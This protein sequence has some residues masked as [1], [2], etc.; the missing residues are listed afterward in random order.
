[1]FKK[2]DL[3]KHVGKARK[4]VSLIALYLFFL[5][6]PV[7]VAL[8]AFAGKPGPAPTIPYTITPLSDIG[9]IGFYGD[10]I[11]LDSGQ[12][13]ERQWPTFSWTHPCFTEFP[14][15]EV[16]FYDG[17]T[18]R[19]LTSND[20]TDDRSPVLHNGRVA[21]YGNIISNINTCEMVSEIFFYDGASVKQISNNNQLGI[22][23]P[24]THS[25]Q[26]IW[27]QKVGT[28]YELFSYDGTSTQ[29]ITS[30]GNYRNAVLF[31][32]KIALTLFDGNDTEVYIW[33]N[34]AMTQ[35]TNNNYDDYAGRFD[36]RYLWVSSNTGTYW[37]DGVSMREV[38]LPAINWNDAS[39]SNGQVVWS[40]IA[41]TSKRDTDTEI[42]FWDGSTTRQL[43]NNSY[44]D[45]NP[46]IHNG[47]VAWNGWDG[48]DWEVYVWNGTAAYQLTNNTTDDGV[49][50]INNGQVV[51]NGYL[52]TPK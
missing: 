36:G 43:T 37:W 14:D 19:Q 47:Q 11:Q 10:G 2:K 18:T 1:M 3:M 39:V 9:L 41:S 24:Q 22:D 29:Q 32:G 12:L 5:A 46:R 27:R 51:W 21:W 30:G 42:F 38:T 31:N 35:F 52:A 45:K 34:G 7:F 50:A 44:D 48:N 33:E 16:V 23:T 28:A 26:V 17:T 25:G 20:D 40:A 8:P 15:S 6:I 4:I 13:A 49:M